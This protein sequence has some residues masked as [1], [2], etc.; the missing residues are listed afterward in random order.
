MLNVE[1]Y[2]LIISLDTFFLLPF[3]YLS[4]IDYIITR[5]AVCIHKHFKIIHQLEQNN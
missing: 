1:T 4:T 5:E 3:N 2:C